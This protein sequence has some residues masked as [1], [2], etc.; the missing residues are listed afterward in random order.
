MDKVNN[1]TGKRIDVFGVGVDDL[2]QKEA[3]SVILRLARL[4]DRGHYAVTVN[5]EFVM[6]A[7]RNHDFARILANSDVA[8][9]D[10]WW[11]ANSR[12]ICGGREQ[13]RVTGV[14][15][16]EN[17]CKEVRDKP[18]RIGFLGGFGS[19]AQEVGKRQQ[20]LHPGLKVVFAEPGVPTI[21][22][23]LRLKKQ[24]DKVGRIDVLFVAYG[25]GRQEFWIERFRK[26]VDV[27]VFIGV[28]GAFDYLAGKKRRA[29]KF[30]QRF[31]FE[32]LWRLVMEPT[33][34]WRQRI[35]PIFFLMFLKK[36]F[37]KKILTKIF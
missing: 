9:A 15:L 28:G 29:P 32:W 36:F 17:V 31:G 19:V 16:V 12:L 14:D 27:G 7:H 33:R 18:V 1:S 23:D 8:V 11:V 20:E 6:M 5:S 30:M 21:S 24:I 25:M 10:G 26:K 13:D 34:I 2:S 3:V 35:I 37:Q 4:N 22:Y